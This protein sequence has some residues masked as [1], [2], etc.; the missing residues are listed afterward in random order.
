MAPAASA[1][2]RVYMS[3]S[4]GLLFAAEDLPTLPAG[5]DY[6]LWAIVAGKPIS[7]GV[8]GLEANGRAQLLANAPPGPADAFAVTIEPAG[9]VPAPTSAPV[10]L[11]PP[12]S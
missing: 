8:F 7:H 4:R 6:Q 10:L 2:A 12:T 5:R 3:P 11:G 1:R 9:G